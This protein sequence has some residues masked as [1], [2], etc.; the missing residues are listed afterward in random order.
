MTRW[1]RAH[2]RAADLFSI[3][4]LTLLWM[5]YFWRLMAP[6][7]ADRVSYPA[8]DYAGQFLAFGAYQAERLTQGEIPLWNPYNFGGHPFL[9]DTQAAVF[10]PPRL[11]TIFLSE[12]L[13]EGWNYAALQAETI[14]HVWLATVLMYIFVKTVTGSRAAGLVSALVIGYGGYLAGYPPQQLAVLEA[15]VWLPLALLGLHQAS[16]SA[17]GWHPPWLAVAAAALGLSLL[18]GHP[19]T[20]LFFSYVMLA[21]GIYRARGQRLK[22]WPVAIPFVLGYGLAMVQL[23]P[24]FEYTRETIR[25]EFGF[26]ALANGFP[27]V[28]LLT[29]VLPNTLSRWSPLYIGIVTLPLIGVALVNKARDAAFWSVTALVG[30]LLSFGGSALLFNVLYLIV[31]GFGW[32]RGQER[33]A[34]VVAHSAAI[35]AGLGVASLRDGWDPVKLLRWAAVIA[36]V[37]AAQLMILGLA[38]PDADLYPAMN[39]AALTALLVTLSWLAFGPLRER[40]SQPAW[41]ALVIGLLVFDLFT[42][43]MGTDMEP[44]AARDRQLYSCLLYT[45]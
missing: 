19:Q 37:G 5:L 41:V 33:A 39:A 36:W 29:V 13:F 18:A 14:A 7:P 28:D 38:L 8:G 23:L 6:N 9:A 31:P 21:Y 43:T 3:L 2:P 44:I 25:A 40:L 12:G 35:L 26:E 20:T 16:E 22:V 34:F 45:S 24:G 10:Y 15:G 4:G 11:V 27:F 32:F 42:V 30:L 1:L 17:E